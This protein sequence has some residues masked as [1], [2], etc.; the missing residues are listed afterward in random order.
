MTD[1]I[2]LYQQVHKEDPGYGKSSETLAQYIKPMLADI[3]PPTLLDYG[4]GKSRVA[5]LLNRYRE[6]DIYFY[7]PAIPGYETLPVKSC[8]FVINTDVMEHIPEHELDSI[9]HDI[10]RLSDYAFFS[11]STRY[12]SKVL[13]NGENAHCTVHEPEWWVDF[14]KSYFPVVTV[15]PGPKPKTANIITW[16][17]KKLTLLRLHLYCQKQALK[18]KIQTLYKRLKKRISRYLIKPMQRM[19]AKKNG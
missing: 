17:P 19:L 12:A 5:H 15:L 13:P 8:D 18:R 11:I 3:Q 6:M 4:C 1:Y 16:Q 9:L 2:Q 10:S 7:D 14:I